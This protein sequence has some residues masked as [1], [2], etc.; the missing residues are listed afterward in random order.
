MN[1]ATPQPN[2]VSEQIKQTT[3]PYCGV[4]CGVDISC[5]VSERTLTLDNVK[6]TPEHPANFGR[7]C[8]K[9]TNLLETNDLKGRLL[10]P[11]VAGKLVDWDTATSMIASKITDTIS[12]YGPDAVAFY[13]SGQLLTEDYYIANKL[14]KGFIGSAN[15]DTNSR[16]CMSSAVAA[17]KRAFGEDVV[18]CDYSDLENTDV[19]VITGSNAAWAH[20]VLFQRIQRAKLKKPEMKVVVVDPRKTETCTIADLHLPIK[21]GSDVALFNGLLHHAQQNGCVN[22]AEVSQF[23]QGLDAT[24]ESVEAYTLKEVAKRC[25]VGSGLLTAFYSLF[26]NAERAVT[27][28]SMG[29]NQS[30]SGVDKAQS[31]INCHLALDLIGKPGCGPFSITGQPNA[32]GGREVGGLANMLAAHCDLENPDHVNAVKTYWNAPAM[33]AKTGLKAVDLFDAIAKGTVK[34]VWIM[35]TNPVVS[36]PNRTQVEYALSQCEMV[37]VSDIVEQNDTLKFAH[38]A[39]P[40]TGWSEKDGTVTNSERRISRQRGLLLPPGSAKHD[41][42]IM[43]AVAKKMGFEKAFDFSHPSQIFNEYVGLTSYKNHQARLLDLSPLQNLS[44]AQYNSLQP[45]QWPMRKG[46]TGE[47]DVVSLRP[48]A[49]KKFSTPNQKAKLIP[50][51]HTLP[52]QQTNHAFPFVLNSGRARDQWHTMTRTGKAAKLLA[53]MPTGHIHIHPKDAEA[54]CLN[55]GSLAKI[56]SEVLIKANTDTQENAVIYPVKLDEAQRPGE[57]FIPI[58]WSAQWGS[59]STLGALYDSAVDPISGQPELKHAAVCLKLA[60]YS[61]HGEIFFNEAVCEYIT[62]SMFDYW[63]KTLLAAQNDVS[64]ERVENTQCTQLRIASNENI[65]TLFSS[66]I[67][68]LP[69]SAVVYQTH[70]RDFSVCLAFIE[71]KLCY[72][73]FVGSDPLLQKAKWSMPAQWLSALVGQPIEETTRQKLMR[74]EIDEA[75]AQGNVVCSCFNVRE[76][77]IEKAISEGSNTVEQ[78]GKKLKC[79][80]NC[81]SCKPALANI[82]ETVVIQ[83]A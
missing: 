56:S 29:I 6:G 2:I 38:V 72:A 58:H 54:L 48:F 4:G 22:H 64:E 25:D 13:V 82:I 23:A 73:A 78:L 32:M 1:M 57:V 70:Q 9:G 49:N 3:C 65:K 5:N 30:S 66:V 41:W 45:V 21:P 77:T 67:A 37:V 59:H 69:K 27:F 26:C 52:L 61:S 17:Y 12:Q 20:P 71:D 47:P 36:M 8:V 18:P 15:I 33:P 53:N 80:T 79:G 40:A 43:C 46:Q 63:S 55:D 68:L 31:I 35:G 81:G 50:V 7:L 51:S 10:H 74:C 11:T 24:L 28:Y 62:L 60:E 76:K 42:Q 44:V 14:M 19:L 34:F 16:L 83:N 75:F 39:L